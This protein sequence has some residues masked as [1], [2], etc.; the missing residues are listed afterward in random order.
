MLARDEFCQL[1]WSDPAGVGSPV[2]LNLCAIGT[3]T[4]RY[5]SWQDYRRRRLHFAR[6]RFWLDR[7]YIRF[8]G[9]RFGRYRGGC[10]CGLSGCWLRLRNDRRSRT[11]I[12]ILRMNVIGDADYHNKNKNDS[13]T[14]RVAK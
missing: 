6:C 12:S 11:F 3:R 9:N 14:H 8:S 5:R 10:R 4:Y 2:Q 1:D 7:D 13:S